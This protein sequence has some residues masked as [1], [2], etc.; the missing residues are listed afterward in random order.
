MGNSVYLGETTWQQFMLASLLASDSHC[1]AMVIFIIYEGP[2]NVLAKE[3]N[4]LPPQTD[5]I[6]FDKD[7]HET[8]LNKE[9]QFRDCP[10]MWQPVI[11]TI[12]QM[13]WDGTI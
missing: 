10:P 7:K 2:G 6:M 11:N 4:K 8:E 3:R 12:V 9:L 1:Y 13:F 5:L